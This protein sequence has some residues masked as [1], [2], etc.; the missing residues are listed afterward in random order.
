M[1]LTS[2]RSPSLL[3]LAALLLGVSSAHAGGEARLVVRVYDAATGA[4]PARALAIRTAS[5]IVE[6]AGVAATW[7]DCTETEAPTACLA[8]RG[9]RDLVVRIMPAAS[10]P[11]RASA[12]Q[13]RHRVD[14]PAA[15]L[16]FAVIDPRTRA[17]EMATV[18]H[19]EV[20]SVAARTGIDLG[21]LLGRTIAHEVGHLLFRVPG[22]SPS[23]LMRAVW[24]DEEIAAGR[25]EDWLFAA[26]DLRLMREPRRVSAA[27]APAR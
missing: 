27:P 13:A 6:A 10:T 3:A 11:V 20:A 19:D 17:A 22:H 4:A 14:E 23:G 1:S 8:P 2:T 9:A 7:I 24:T 18:F 26:S 16:G 21:A 25:D 15:P 5:A 12:V